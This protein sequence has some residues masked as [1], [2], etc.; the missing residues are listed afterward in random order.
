MNDNDLIKDVLFRLCSLPGPSGYEAPIAEEIQKIWKCYVDET[1]ISNL[2]NLYAA[3]KANIPMEGKQRSVLFATHMDAVGMIV[4]ELVGEFIRFAEIGGLDPRVLPGQFVN[5]HTKQGPLKGLI[6][7]PARSLTKKDYGSAPI[8]LAELLI[9]TG[10]EAEEL[11]KLVRPGDIITYANDPVLMQEKNLLAHTLDNRASIAAVT[12]C[13]Q[14]LQSILHKWNVYAVG[15]VQEE[16]TMAGAITAPY[17]LRPDIAIAI[18][19]THGT[20]PL[21]KGWYTFPLES[22][23][24]LSF[25][26]NIHP[27]LYEIFK[28]TCE[29]EHIPY[30]TEYSPRMS[31]TDAYEMQVTTQGVSTMVV[32]IPLRYMHTANELVSLE[33]IRNVGKLL[34]AFVRQLDE[35]TMNRLVWED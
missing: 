29:S 18:D 14:E 33:D 34:A 15:T 8:P 17:D 21:A 32:S 19:V 31:G 4:T 13:L 35:N 5:I 1:R 10:Y 11:K 2:G 12:L 28:Q 27:G 23:P 9:D 7:M 24:V 26:M 16:E 30:A 6:V 25:G 20:S 3:K 22:G